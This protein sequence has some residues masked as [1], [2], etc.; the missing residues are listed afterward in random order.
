[1]AWQAKSWKITRQQHIHSSTSV[2]TYLG[3]DLVL[4]LFCEVRFVRFTNVPMMHML[5]G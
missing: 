3:L 2:P 5:W 1:M 4:G